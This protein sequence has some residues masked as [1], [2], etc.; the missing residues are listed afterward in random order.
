M[1]IEWCGQR[2]YCA[3]SA[4]HA[5]QIPVTGTASLISSA[6]RL[7]A[8]APTLCAAVRGAA[9][10]HRQQRACY[11]GNPAPEGNATS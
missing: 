6:L 2:S 3:S 4:S 1:H 11:R 9:R 7:K 8:I 5:L 10:N